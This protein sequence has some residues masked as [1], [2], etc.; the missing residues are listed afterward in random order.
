MHEIKETGQIVASRH[1]VFVGDDGSTE[2][3]FVKIGKPHEIN[4][5]KD[6]CC[7]YEI[8]SK[9]RVKRYGIIGI[10]TVQALELTLR[11]IKP[12]LEY[13]ERVNKGKFHFLDEEGHCFA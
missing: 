3:V 12:E 1:L 2:D 11:T 6:C 4:D 9:S 7:P 5:Q 13:W 10:D 8:S